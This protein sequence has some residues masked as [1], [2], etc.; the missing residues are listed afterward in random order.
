MRLPLTAAVCE[1]SASSPSLS[2]LDSGFNGLDTRAPAP[3]RC[4]A[5]RVIRK[6]ERQFA[7]RGAQRRQ[8]HLG[9]ARAD[10]DRRVAVGQ[11]GE[12]GGQR[13]AVAGGSMMVVGNT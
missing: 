13:R 6:A 4:P 11:I 2:K 1:D 10:K 5:R 12:R 9:S 8:R 7:W 3:R